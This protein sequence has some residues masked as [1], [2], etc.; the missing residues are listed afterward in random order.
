MWNSFLAIVL[1][2]W[3]QSVSANRECKIEHAVSVCTNTALPVW[4]EVPSDSSAAQHSRRLLVRLTPHPL[5][6]PPFSSLLFN[7]SGNLNHW[8][9]VSES[10][11]YTHREVLSCMVIRPSNENGSVLF[12][13]ELWLP[14]SPRQ[15]VVWTPVESA[16]KISVA[17]RKGSVPE[18]WG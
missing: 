6:P 18:W 3:I 11:A 14:S 10:A 1:E 5:P 9:C 12:L 2:N 13:T 16:A 8:K 4:K 7:N 17:L 15:R